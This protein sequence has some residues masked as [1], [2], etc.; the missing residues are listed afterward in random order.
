MTQLYVGALLERPPGPKYLEAL[1]F[2]EL[3]FPGSLPSSKVVTRFKESLPEGFRVA[4]VAPTAAR[5]LR[6]GLE[7]DERGKEAL[8]WLREAATTL[9][10]D[11]VVPTA[12]GL[13]TSGRD[14]ERLRAY[15][16]ALPDIEGRIK[17]WAPRGLW[18]NE[19]AY[20]M[21]RELGVVCAHDPLTDEPFEGTITYGRIE[22]IGA[23]QRFG[24]GLL[25]DALEALLAGE[26][27]VAFAAIESPRSFNEAV[28]LQ[29]LARG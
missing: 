6:G 11:I 16:E 8:L 1:P 2:A 26:P 23:R 13:T 21:A 20:P 3:S 22:A 5:G 10:A 12:G 9:H 17:V 27:D 29:Q 15:F 25:Y 7:L 28:A 4:L 18:E 19:L 14:R 24:E